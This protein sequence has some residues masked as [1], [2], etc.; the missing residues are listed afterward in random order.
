MR[1]V[2]DLSYYQIYLES[3]RPQSQGKDTY[4]YMLKES[5]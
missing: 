3:C 5:V 1:E 2:E 4:L